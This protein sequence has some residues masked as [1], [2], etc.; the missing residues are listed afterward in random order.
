MGTRRSLAK[1]IATLT[2]IPELMLE[3]EYEALEVEMK[4]L[5]VAER[6]SWAP[7]RETSRGED[8]AYSLMV[9]A[10]KDRRSFDIDQP[11]I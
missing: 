5:V 1:V 7:L 8:R 9:S 4:K 10:P 3:H 6:L 11:T 2:A